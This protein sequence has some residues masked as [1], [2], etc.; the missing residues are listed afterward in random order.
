MNSKG[1]VLNEEIAKDTKIVSSHNRTSQGEVLHTP[2]T[3]HG[4]PLPQKERQALEAKQAMSR[5]RSVLVMEHPFFATL[6]LRLHLKADDSC[7]DLWTDGKTLGYNAVYAATLPLAKLVG[8]QAHEVLHIAFAH[9]FRRQGR[10]PTLWNKAC[11][12]SINPILLDAG[13]SLP[14]GFAHNPDSRCQ[15]FSLEGWRIE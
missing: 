9:H 4:E 14:Q 13:F 1:V 7:V 6:A 11:D 12:L 2:K 8:A 10:D 5:A 15:K 3:C